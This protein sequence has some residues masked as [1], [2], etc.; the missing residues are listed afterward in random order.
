MRLIQFEDTAGRKV[1]V[2]PDYVFAVAQYSDYE[3]LSVICAPGGPGM[4]FTVKGTPEYVRE[5]LLGGER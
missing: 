5:R 3:D 2:N 1:L 4:S